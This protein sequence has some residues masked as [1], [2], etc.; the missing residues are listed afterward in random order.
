MSRV[1]LVRERF[2]LRFARRMTSL[3]PRIVRRL[4]GPQIVIDGQRLNP[5]LQLILRLRQL[6][7]A[8]GAT[9]DTPESSRSR[10]VRETRTFAGLPRVGGPVRDFTIPGPAGEIPVRRLGQRQELR[11]LRG[12][13]AQ[14]AH[15]LKQQDI[16]PL[17]SQSAL[18]IFGRRHALGAADA[19]GDESD[20]RGESGQCRPSADAT[21]PLPETCRRM[22]RCVTKHDQSP[23]EHSGATAG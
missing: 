7:G 4:A 15:G 1:E 3:P 8:I 16:L 12:R 19:P 2:E 20:H 22:G 9:A 11:K 17:L 13:E 23:F 14:V 10:L 5:Q 21:T 18:R 6:N